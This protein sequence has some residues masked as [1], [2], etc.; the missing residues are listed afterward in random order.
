MAA[1][2]IAITKPLMM[3]PQIELSGF[4]VYLLGYL[5]WYWR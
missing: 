5:N 3:V 1:M 4:I 2:I